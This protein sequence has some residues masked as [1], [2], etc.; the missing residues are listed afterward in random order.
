[1][2]YGLMSMQ[3]QRPL[4]RPSQFPNSEPLPR[5]SLWLIFPAYIVWRLGSDITST[6]QLANRATAKT[7]KQ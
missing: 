2:P 4:G 1:M 6:L 7:K 3:C 5:L